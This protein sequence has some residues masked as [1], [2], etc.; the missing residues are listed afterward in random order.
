M[1]A[2]CAERSW[3]F[4]NAFSMTAQDIPE[5]AG[6]SA[7]GIA[8]RRHVQELVRELE[9]CSDCRCFVVSSCMG[10]GGLWV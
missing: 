2:M 6:R 1:Q 8:A 4:K 5:D 7:A 10:N 3:P 9:D